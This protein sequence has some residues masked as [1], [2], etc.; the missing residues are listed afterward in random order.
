MSVFRQYTRMKERTAAKEKKVALRKQGFK[1]VV[2]R[3]GKI[4]KVPVLQPYVK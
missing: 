2:S 4:Y 1:E 3:K